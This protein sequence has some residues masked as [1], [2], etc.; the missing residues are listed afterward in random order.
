[1][2]YYHT[3]GLIPFIGGWMI[4]SWLV[5]VVLAYLVYKDA[6][7]RLAKRRCS[8]WQHSVQRPD[9]RKDSETSTSVRPFL[10]AKRRPG[11]EEG[12]LT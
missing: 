7:K 6:E 9:F 2:P 11:L 1:M 10:R 5:F 3:L 8:P 4:L 12:C